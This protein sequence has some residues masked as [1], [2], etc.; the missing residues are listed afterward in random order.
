MI[1]YFAVIVSMQPNTGPTQCEH[2]CTIYVF[3]T[4]KGATI[5]VAAPFYLNLFLYPIAPARFSTAF[6][7]PHLTMDRPEVTHPTVD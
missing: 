1:V 6:E 3:D 7:Q 5:N 4:Q 2:V